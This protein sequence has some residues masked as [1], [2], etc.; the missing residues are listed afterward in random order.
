MIITYNVRLFNKKV[1]TEPKVSAE[2]TL[3]SSKSL[4]T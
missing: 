4:K 1:S 3:A 2:P